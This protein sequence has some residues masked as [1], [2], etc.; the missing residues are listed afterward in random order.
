MGA[1]LSWVQYLENAEFVNTYMYLGFSGCFMILPPQCAI[2]GIY[3]VRVKNK[4][5]LP[6]R[7]PFPLFNTYDN[8]S[9]YNKNPNGWQELTNSTI[10]VPDE[11]YDAWLPYIQHAEGCPSWMGNTGIICARISELPPEQLAKIK[12]SY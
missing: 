6:V 4:I 10:Y 12:V 7:T 5:V 9:P 11:S 3:L 1:D 2:N 8:S